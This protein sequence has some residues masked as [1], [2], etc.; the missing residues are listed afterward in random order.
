MTGRYY[1]EGH[2]EHFYPP[3]KFDIINEFVS[4]IITNTGKFPTKLDWVDFNKS[5]L[6]KLLTGPC[7]LGISE[8]GYA[9]R[10]SDVTF[11]EILTDLELLNALK[12]S[13]KFVNQQYHQNWIEPVWENQMKVTTNYTSAL[14][15]PKGLTKHILTTP[16]L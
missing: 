16:F 14:E 13:Q 1:G 10:T 9:N 8:R 15:S 7:T 11:N 6:C 5:E 12:D 2:T 4:A 3:S